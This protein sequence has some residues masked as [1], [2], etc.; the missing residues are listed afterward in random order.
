MPDLALRSA[1]FL[2]LFAALAHSFIGERH[3]FPKLRLEPARLTLLFRAIWHCLSAGW[4]AGA[5]LLL[6][7][8]R[9]GAKGAILLVA[10][11]YGGAAL[12]N[13]IGTRGRHFGWAVLAAASLLALAG[14]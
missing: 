6:S 11:L 7:T 2:G 8:P 5:L 14:R 13:A 10:A 3:I 12:G 9:E 1:A 4:V